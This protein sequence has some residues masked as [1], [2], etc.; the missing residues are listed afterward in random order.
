MLKDTFG[1]GLAEVNEDEIPPRCR[2]QSVVH[3]IQPDHVLHIE[4]YHLEAGVGIYP[5]Q[6]QQ[7]APILWR[8]FSHYELHIMQNVVAL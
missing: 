4:L 7:A 3:C 6:Q 5:T 1:K 2:T 8:R